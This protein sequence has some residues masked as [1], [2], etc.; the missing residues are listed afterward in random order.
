MKRIILISL[1]LI[2]VLGFSASALDFPQILP[3]LKIELVVPENIQVGKPFWVDVYLTPFSKETIGNTKI[4]LKTSSSDLYF[5]ETIWQGDIFGKKVAY[6]IANEPDGSG[7]TLSYYAGKA[8]SIQGK[9]KMASVMM[10]AKKSGTYSINLVK[11]NSYSHY[12]EFI[13][14]KITPPYVLNMPTVTF[15]VPKLGTC[16]EFETV[17]IG[18][19]PASALPNCGNLD[20]GC[21]KVINC[22]KCDHY[23][24]NNYCMHP[25]TVLFPPTAEEKEL[26]ETVLMVTSGTPTDTKLEINLFKGVASALKKQTFK[27]KF[28][29]IVAALTIWFKAAKVPQP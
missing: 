24:V 29:D 27:E 3:S 22:G 23:C 16:S 13:Q 6:I 9:Q 11:E 21:G 5:G 7:I 19:G 4:S 25:N 28:D 2:V 18:E 14:I 20:N 12:V 26:C 15:C 1:F 10:M 8:V 17:K